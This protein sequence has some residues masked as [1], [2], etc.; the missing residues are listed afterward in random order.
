MRNSRRMADGDHERDIAF[1]G[2]LR[3]KDADYG[4]RLAEALGLD[5]P[6]GRTALAGLDRLLALG[7]GDANESSIIDVARGRRP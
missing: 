6:L 7:L 5:A 4:V 1:S 3:H 2:R